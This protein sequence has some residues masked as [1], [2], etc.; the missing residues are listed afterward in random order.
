VQNFLLHYW[1]AKHPPQISL[2]F[3][4]LLWHHLRTETAELRCFITYNNMGSKTLSMECTFASLTHQMKKT[5]KA[6]LAFGNQGKAYQHSKTLFTKK[7]T[8]SGFLKIH[9]TCQV[10]KLP[11]SRVLSILDQALSLC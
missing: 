2:V 9:F 4:L 5:L 6:M 7:L 1:E 10:K 3:F 11:A 8:M